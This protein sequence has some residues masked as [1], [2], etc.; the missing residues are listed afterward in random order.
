VV[1]FHGVLI[2]LNVLYAITF[3]IS[4]LFVI[5]AI[6]EHL[7]LDRLTCCSIPSS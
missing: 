6:N 3:P 7:A 1:G 2:Q 4:S 5:V